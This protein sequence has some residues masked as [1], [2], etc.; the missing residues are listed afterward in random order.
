MTW[1]GGWLAMDTGLRRYDG[2]GI[3]CIPDLCVMF[4]IGDE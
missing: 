3:V 2:G 1:G 4:V